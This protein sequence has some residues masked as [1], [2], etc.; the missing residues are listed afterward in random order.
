MFCE[1]YRFVKSYITLICMNIR[2][3]C[4]FNKSRHISMKKKGIFLSN[5]RQVFKK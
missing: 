2:F 5:F 4:N 1:T 3:L